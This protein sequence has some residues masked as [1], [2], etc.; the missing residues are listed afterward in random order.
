M[1]EEVLDQNNVYVSFRVGEE[2]YGLSIDEVRQIIR[3]PHITRVPKMPDYVLGMCNQRGEVIP[4][5]DLSLRLGYGE[6][7]DYGEDSRVIIVDKE[8]VT[9]GF[10]VE[11]VSEVKST[12]VQDVDNFPDLL[13]AGV[14]KR[15][16]SGIIKVQEGDE[17][18]IIQIINSDEIMDFDLVRQHVEQKGYKKSGSSAVEA[19][20]NVVDEKRF[21]SFNINSQEYAIEIHKINE[22]IWMPEVT[23]VPGLSE[24][25]LGIFSLRGKVIPLLS[26]HSKFGKESE[27]EKESTRIVIV[28]INDVLIAFVADKVNAVLSVDKGLIEPPPKVF[29]DEDSEIAS[30]LKLDEGARLVMV[31]EPEN[32]IEEAELESLKVVASQ[33]PESVDMENIEDSSAEEKQIVTFQIESEDYGIY[34]DKVQEINRYTNVT[35]VPKT[36]K[37]VEGIINLRGEVIP[38]I[39]LRSRFELEPKERDEFTR[40]IIVNLMKMKVGFV[41]DWVDEVLRIGESNIDEVPPVLSASVN[42]EFIEGVVNLEDKQKMI[43]LLSV[44]E[45]FSESE[46]GKLEKMQEE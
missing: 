42:A 11:A 33:S 29:G 23:S 46:I 31:L 6:P 45:L 22:I 21:I 35:K 14:D 30:V 5:I 7:C 43:L 4:L 27:T 10:A 15:Y 13:S 39:D 18:S 28:D 32:L 40:V 9:T 44:D 24:Y 1:S 8:G 2:I 3:I 34:I 25:V 38:L 37:F 20:G 16:I 19:A 26:L 17:V 12:E 36:P 41:V